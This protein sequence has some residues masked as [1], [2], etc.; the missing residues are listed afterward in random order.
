MSHRGLAG[1]KRSSL[2]V[3]HLPHVA[4]ALY[5]CLTQCPKIFTVRCAHPLLPL[6]WGLGLQVFHKLPH[7]Y[8]LCLAKEDLFFGEETFA[9]GPM[10]IDRGFFC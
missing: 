4:V 3:V 8:S 1:I 2:S 5:V 9:H 7:L 6:I 10:V